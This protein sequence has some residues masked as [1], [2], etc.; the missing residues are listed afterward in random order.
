MDLHFTVRSDGGRS[1]RAGVGP[2]QLRFDMPPRLGGEGKGPGPL[3]YFVVSAAACFHYAAT[4]ALAELGLD[5]AGVVVHVHATMAPERRVD[6]LRLEV[7]LPSAFGED[8]RAAVDAAVKS[9]PIHNTLVHP[10]SLEIETRLEDAQSK[11]QVSPR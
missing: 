10:P 3:A 11:S 2:H 8:A 4:G 9:C 7:L 6:V 1:S 5:T